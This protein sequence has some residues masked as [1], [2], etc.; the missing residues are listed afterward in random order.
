MASLTKAEKENW[1]TVLTYISR[2]FTLVEATLQPFSH[3]AACLGKRWGSCRSPPPH[4]HRQLSIVFAL[5]MNSVFV[6]GSNVFYCVSWEMDFLRLFWPRVAWMG[7][8][9]LL[10]HSHTAS[11]WECHA[12]ILLSRLLSLVRRSTLGRILVVHFRLVEATVVSGTFSVAIIFS[13]FVS[14]PQS[15]FDTIPSLCSEGYS[16]GWQ[17]S[18]FGFFPTFSLWCA[19]SAMTITIGILEVFCVFK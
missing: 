14:F 13:F 15:V 17:F 7:I 18:W 10:K 2:L 11:M 3:A 8:V 19:T 1:N 6:V 12:E 5:K 16:W 4:S 9:D